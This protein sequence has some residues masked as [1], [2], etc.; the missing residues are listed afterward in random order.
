MKPRAHPAAVAGGAFLHR[1]ESHRDAML[2][3]LARDSR[4]KLKIARSHRFRADAFVVYAQLNRGLEIR[5]AQIR[6]H[7]AN[8]ERLVP[9]R[10]FQSCRTS[11]FH[12]RVRIDTRNLP[13]RVCGVG[14]N[15]A[16][17]G[18]VTRSAAGSQ[19]QEKGTEKN[20]ENTGLGFHTSGK[21]DSS[22]QQPLLSFDEPPLLGPLSEELRLPYFIDRVIGMLHD[23]ELV[24][25]DLA[26]RRPLLDAQP[27][28]LPHVYTHRRNAFPL[29]ADQL[30][31][32]ILIQRLLLPLFAKPQRLAGF[33]IAHH[34]QE[35]VFL[36]PIDLIDTHLPQRRLPPLG[37]PSL[38]VP[39]I[40]G[41]D[42]ALRQP[43]S[44][45]YLARRRTL[46]RLADGVLKTLAEGRLARQ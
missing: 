19:Q 17:P 37:I 6:N 22:A 44:S 26:L 36:A 10:L 18:A 32:E 11:L 42:R 5:V 40:D 34:G 23:M 45:R 33:Q 30:G 28:R 41:S 21:L 24:V 13:L 15:P 14:R 20:S 25:D 27:E 3:R 8:G 9:R 1:A 31:A 46:T 29:P 2:S 39:Q 4:R 38:Q 7:S 43:H 35:L 12:P 16:Q